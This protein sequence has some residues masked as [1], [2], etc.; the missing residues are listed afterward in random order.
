MAALATYSAVPPG[1]RIRGAPAAK[2]SM[3]AAQITKLQD[4]SDKMFPVT[5]TPYFTDKKLF[6]AS[7]EGSTSSAQPQVWIECAIKASR[8]FMTPNDA[9]S[10]YTLSHFAFV[11]Y[12][13]HH[14]TQTGTPAEARTPLASPAPL[15]SSSLPSP[16][17]AC[18]L[19]F[20]SP[21][22]DR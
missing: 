13:A 19:P 3:V 17:L 14:H 18:S 16:C 8:S 21:V 20:P 7:G 11:L 9:Q 10:D 12:Y 4:I 15:L 6:K 5:R 22:L 1:G 2:P